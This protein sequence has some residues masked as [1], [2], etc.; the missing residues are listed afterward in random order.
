LILIKSFKQLV[1][2]IQQSKNEQHQHAIEIACA[3]LLYEV[4]RADDHFSPD[5]QAAL[6]LLIKQRFHLSG[7]E[8]KAIV[9]LATDQ[10]ESATD[11]Y[12]FTKVVNEQ[13]SIQDKR[14]LLV[15]LWRVAN[16][17]DHVDPHEEHT[18]R[19]IADLLN[20]RHSEFIQSKHQA[21]GI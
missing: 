7:D 15:M 6:N 16:I 11:Y 19:R 1:Q 5:E 2:N 8:I 3:A 10:V 12:Q 13:L 21:L 4:A 20:L 14:E 9:K 17:D 18:I